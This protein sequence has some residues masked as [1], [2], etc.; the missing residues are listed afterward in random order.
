[1]PRT[2]GFLCLIV[3]CACG[4]STPAGGGDAGVDAATLAGTWRLT[5]ATIGSDAGALT[6]TDMNQR[7]ADPDTGA[8]HDYRVN[9]TLELTTGG[10]LAYAEQTVVDDTIPLTRGP[11]LADIIAPYTVNGT[12]TGTLVLGGSLPTVGFVWERSPIEKLKVVLDAANQLEFQRFT[13]SSVD[14]FP[15]RGTI[16]LADGTPAFH[17]PHLSIAFLLR[18]GFSVDPLDDKTIDFA[19]TNHASFQRDRIEGAL[20]IQRIAFGNSAIAIGLI[21]VWDDLDGDGV[22]G[23]T[24]LDQCVTPIPPGADCLRGVAPVYLTAR[25]RSGVSA[26]LSASPYAFLRSGWTQGVFIRD[27]RGQ[28]PRNGVV[29]LDPTMLVPFDVYVPQSPQQTFVPVLDF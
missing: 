10:E 7:L 18:N 2:L 4:G 12:D 21:V 29:S 26:E 3:T 8:M 25:S 17:A 20:G 6:L 11:Q 5:S 14:V 27:L 13:P 28:F 16:T 1:M 24:L 9:G 19:G 22:P 23:D 15:V